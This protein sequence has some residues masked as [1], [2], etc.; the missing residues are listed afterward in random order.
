MIVNSKRMAITIYPA[1]DLIQTIKPME[2]QK[3]EE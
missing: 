1:P 2:M 3:H